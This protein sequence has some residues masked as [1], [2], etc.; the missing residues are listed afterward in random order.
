MEYPVIDLQETGKQIRALRKERHLSVRTVCEF[1]GGISQQAVYK[2]EAG[3]CLPSL[4]NMYALSKLF[5]V[6]IND[7][8]EETRQVSSVFCLVY[9]ISFFVE[10]VIFELENVSIGH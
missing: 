10:I 5:Q 6:S 3:I 2:W 8:I 4:D 7:M 1:M 9:R